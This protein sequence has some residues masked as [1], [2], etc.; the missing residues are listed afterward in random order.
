[1][2]YT[3]FFYNRFINKTKSYTCYHS[4]AMKISKDNQYTRICRHIYEVQ[5]N[6]LLH[7]IQFPY[8]R[9]TRMLV[10]LMESVR[11]C[12]NSIKYSLLLI[13]SINTYYAYKTRPSEYLRVL[14]LKAILKITL[15]MR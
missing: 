6:L 10:K 14:K 8:Y 3:I 1:M 12:V 4:I 13:V 15:A 2:H 11:G 5:E 7:L 9:Q